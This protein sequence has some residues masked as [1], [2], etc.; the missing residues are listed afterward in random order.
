MTAIS[1]RNPAH[2]EHDGYGGL[3]LKTD[4]MPVVRFGLGVLLFGFLGFL[5]WAVLAPLDEGAVAPGVVTVESYRKAI[6][7]QQ[8]G[9][10]KELLVRDGDAVKQGQP[11]VR[12]DEIQAES[13]AG[14]LR[15]QYLGLLAVET[16]LVA[17]RENAAQVPWPKEL[18][19]AREDPQVANV[20][21]VQEDLFRTRRRAYEG[22]LSILRE[23]IAG[24]TEQIKGFEGLV[25]GKEQQIRL[26]DE[27]LASNK[28][29]FEQGFISRSKLYEL[30]RLQA[31]LASSLGEDMSKRA[32]AKQ[33]LAESKLKL[34]QREQEYRREVST[35]L[36]EVQREG[37][38]LREQLNAAEDT[39]RR[40][41]IR[42]PEDGVVV[43]LSV[44]TVG[45]VVKPGETLME[46][47]PQHS[48]LI[49]DAQ[50]QPHD[51]DRVYPGLD[52]EVRFTAFPMASTPI[53]IGKVERVSA[54]RLTDQRTG[55]PYYLTRVLVTAD[56]LTKLGPNRDKVR[57]GMN[58]DVIVKAGERTLFTYLVKPLRDRLAR[59][60]KEE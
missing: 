30:Q 56:E 15:V 59:A 54:D 27:D 52:A 44:H 35:Q 22:E 32:S 60:F 50:V 3:K 12:L 51:V 18:R 29:L 55:Q 1:D 17:E 16:R 8:G 2:D 42:A 37:A 20:L 36:T 58:A 7:H 28:K 49:I 23:S 9:I 4:A 31:D 45:G 11:L 24:F 38:K 6:Q 26:L 46:I 39:A 53:V 14:S 21:R 47:V 10:I 33:A 43:G 48:G 19:E 40:V 5:A 13:L 41:V 57:P 34:L 25:A